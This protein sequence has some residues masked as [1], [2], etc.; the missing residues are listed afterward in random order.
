MPHCGL[1]PGIISI[2]AYDLTGRSMRSTRSGCASAHFH[3]SPSTPYGTTSPGPPDG[4][5]NE[6]CNPCGTIHDGKRIRVMPLEALKRFAV[7]GIDHEAFNTSGGLETLYDTLADRV[8]ELDYKTV[9]YPGHRDMMTFL[10]QDLRLSEPSVGRGTRA[11]TASRGRMPGRPTCAARRTRSTTQTSLLWRKASAARSD[12]PCT[13]GSRTR[14]S[15]CGLP[16]A[17]NRARRHCPRRTSRK[18]LSL[19]GARSARRARAR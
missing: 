2:A 7:D 16:E 3:S 5:I 1:A 18:L 11:A 8:R 15:R 12:S 10:V 19:I 6:C 4:L 13:R 17:L 14:T 9:R